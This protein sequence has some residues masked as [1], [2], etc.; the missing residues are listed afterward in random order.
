MADEQITSNTAN[1]P[2]INMINAGSDQAAPSSGRAVL[3]IK[4]GVAYVRLDTGSPTPVGGAVALAEGQL[5]IG[6]GSGELTALAVGTEGQVVTADASGLA[7]WDDLPA[8]AGGDL[9][10]IADVDVGAGGL[11]NQTFSNIPGTYR[12]LRIIVSGRNDYNAA[13]GALSLTVNGDGG[14]NYVYQIVQTA[15]TAT[16]GQSSGANPINYTVIGQLPGTSAPAGASGVVDIVIPGYAGTT[17]HKGASSLWSARTATG[18]SGMLTG[19][20]AM[21]WLSTAAIT[22]LTLTTGTTLG[23]LEGSRITLYGLK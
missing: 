19:T 7:T 5:A 14:N 22:S 12:A 16:N 18:A 20:G 8:S 15:N 10:K 11:T 4:N 17:F 1:I 23:F 2:Y 6:D 13:T 9:E 21:H 3:Y